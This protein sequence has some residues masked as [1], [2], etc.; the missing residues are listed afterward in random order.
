MFQ[1]NMTETK[2]VRVEELN[3]EK[4]D[5]IMNQI[6]TD[7]L[8]ELQKLEACIKD[9]IQTIIE[10]G[11]VNC[12]EYTIEAFKVDY[13]LDIIEN[14]RKEIE[15]KIYE[16]LKKDHRGLMSIKILGGD[17]LLLNAK[18]DKYEF[19]YSLASIHVKNVV[20]YE[21]LLEVVKVKH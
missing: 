18:S 15:D 17:K 20:I 10:N 13:S 19:E 1:C 6:T 12:E 2:Y 9:N 3:N 11:K 16:T 7:I 21:F 5:E 8:S 14:L 4:I